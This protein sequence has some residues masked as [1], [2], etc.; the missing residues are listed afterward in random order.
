MAQPHEQWLVDLQGSPH[1]KEILVILPSGEAVPIPL[2]LID[3][4]RWFRL[5][6]YRRKEG[7]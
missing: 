7:A 6:E 5:I 4:I 2:E 1:I 3:L